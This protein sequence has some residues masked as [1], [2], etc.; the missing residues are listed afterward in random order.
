MSKTIGQFAYSLRQMRPS[1]R[2][3]FKPIVT[4]DLD[5]YSRGVNSPM[6]SV[7]PHLLSEGEVDAWIQALKEDLDAVGRRAKAALRRANEATDKIVS[8]RISN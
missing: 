6:P 1:D 7:T 4:I 2:L 8:G 3:T 5:H